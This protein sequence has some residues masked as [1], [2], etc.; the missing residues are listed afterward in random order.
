MSSWIQDCSEQSG[1]KRILSE[2]IKQMEPTT[3]IQQPKKRPRLSGGRTACT[4]CKTRKQ[5]YDRHERGPWIF[6][7]NLPIGDI[8]FLSDAD[9]SARRCDDE[10]PKCTNC[11]KAMVDCDKA[12]DDSSSAYTRSLEEK[13][14]ALESRLLAQKQ[15]IQH[16]DQDP[17][18]HE[19]QSSHNAL[20]EVVEALS[21]G[22]F[23]APAYVGSSAGFSLALNLGSMVQASIWNDAMPGGAR[24]ESRGSFGS[25]A[26]LDLAS[27]NITLEEIIANSAEPPDD[28]YGRRLLE[29]Y[30]AQLHQRYP[31]LDIRELWKLHSERLVWR[32]RSIG[33]LSRTERFGIFKLYLV[34][35]IGAMLLNLTEK[36][37]RTSPEVCPSTHLSLSGTLRMLTLNAELLHGGFT[38]YSCCKRVKDSTKH[39]S[40][41]TSCCLSPAFGLKPRNMV[42]DRFSNAH[43]Y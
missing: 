22:N 26:S 6:L 38:A 3:P 43:C 25:P 14:E 36:K 18:H 16:S 7:H 1:R 10:W 19:R 21:Q 24:P 33:S 42:Y 28:E 4:R 15:L 30:C 34:Y 11:Q 37:S 8:L 29:A 13:I 35:A 23:E 17:P 41:D 27:R 39:R 40:H 2:F 9:I 31:F 5:K 32:A 12:Y 20:G